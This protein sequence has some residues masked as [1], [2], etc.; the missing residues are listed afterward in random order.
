MASKGDRA[1][2][3]ADRARG[4]LVL[5]GKLWFVGRKVSLYRDVKEPPDFIEW[6]A[7]EDEMS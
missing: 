4:F 2:G 6:Q 5:V 3:M 7:F 1:V